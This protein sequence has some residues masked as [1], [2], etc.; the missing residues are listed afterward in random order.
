MEDNNLILNYK[1]EKSKN[2]MESII[3]KLISLGIFLFSIEMNTSLF[4][5]HIYG[6]FKMKTFSWCSIFI[7]SICL[8]ILHFGILFNRE[9]KNFI[10]WYYNLQDNGTR[11]KGYVKRIKYIKQNT[12]KLKI[13]YYSKLEKKDIEFYTPIIIIK[14]LEHDKRILCTVYESTQREEKEDSCFKKENINKNKKELTLN[15]YKLFEIMEKRQRKKWFGKAIAQ[16]F[17]YEQS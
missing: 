1:Y 13:C 10:R 9:R 12:Y 14:D 6:Y 3:C 17:Y 8:Y 15:V 4:S 2:R 7:I 11:C 16:D 5:N